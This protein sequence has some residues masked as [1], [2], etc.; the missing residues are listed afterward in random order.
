[1][2]GDDHF[3]RQLIAPYLEGDLDPSSVSSLERHLGE[4]AECRHE[5]RLQRL[6]LCELE[7]ALSAPPQLEVPQDFARI[8]AAQAESDMSGARTGAE[9]KRALQ[10]SALLGLASLSLIGVTAGR[11]LLSAGQML[12]AKIL[13]VISLLGKALYD[14]GAG[15]AVTLR[16]AG[17]ALLPDAFSVL[18]F[19]LLLLAVLLLTILISTYHRYPRRGLYE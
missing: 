17:G 4:C 2:S 12:S 5:T 8:V 15:L 9:R 6:M 10:L 11:S 18:V 16:V 3:Q 1:M 7:A 13:F 19:L 14:A